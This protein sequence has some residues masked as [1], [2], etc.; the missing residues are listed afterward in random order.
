MLPVG[1]NF[2]LLN[3]EEWQRWAVRLLKLRYQLEFV[4]FPDRDKGDFGLEGFC[5]D[6]S[7]FQCYGPE[8]PLDVPALYEKHRI[9][10]TSDVQKLKKN[11][12]RI[13]NAL[14]GTK[15]SRWHLVVPRNESVRI[16]EHAGIKS[17]EV[18]NWNLPFIAPAFAISVI[19]DDYF[20]IERGMLARDGLHTIRVNAPST[21]TQE[22]SAWARSK[23]TLIAVLDGKL[24]RLPA[25]SPET[26]DE[27]REAWLQS[28]LDGENAIEQLERDYGDVFDQF[29]AVKNRHERALRIREQYSTQAPGERL[30]SVL[31][32]FCS[33]VKQEV[34]SLDPGT[35]DTLT[36]AT[37][38]DWMLRCPL[39]FPSNAQAGS[40]ANS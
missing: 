6:G 21:T 39:R 34:P 10:I 37:T 14:A 33:D 8:E 3:G 30:N 20:E 25:V 27:H 18:R 35:V 40:L 32:R 29:V 2:G 22:V 13:E 16:Q 23:S 15:I 9:K 28:F 36:F 5:H 12:A 17:V 1:T 26:L 7:A 38:A 19:T 11:A 31:E 24:L 4:E